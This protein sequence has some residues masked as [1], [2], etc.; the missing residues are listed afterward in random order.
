MLTTFMLQSNPLPRE[1]LL[2]RRQ[3]LVQSWSRLVA[4]LL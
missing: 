2:A 4:A 3:T 1:R